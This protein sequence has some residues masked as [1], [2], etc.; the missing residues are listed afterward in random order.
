MKVNGHISNTLSV[1]TGV[2]QESVLGPLLLF[3]F[4]NDLMA[5]ENCY[6]HVFADNRP[7]LLAVKTLISPPNLCGKVSN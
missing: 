3:M 6:L 1:Q 4:A 5:L 2:P 7:R